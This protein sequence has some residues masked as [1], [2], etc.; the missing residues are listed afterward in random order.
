MAYF[1]PFGDKNGGKL[2]KGIFA[3]LAKL[4]GKKGK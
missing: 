2:F 3:L 4:K 1:P